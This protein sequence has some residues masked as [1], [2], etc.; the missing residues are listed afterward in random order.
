MY[1]Y[2]VLSLVEEITLRAVRNKYEDGW[3]EGARRQY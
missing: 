1:T 3:F 2:L